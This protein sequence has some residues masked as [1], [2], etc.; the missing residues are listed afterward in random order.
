ML[1][2][3]GDLDEKRSVILDH[4]IEIFYQIYFIFK[5][6]RNKNN[7]ILQ[8]NSSDFLFD[9]VAQKIERILDK[10]TNYYSIKSC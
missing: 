9:L 1:I 8:L 6:L 4:E 5:I 10:L 2:N 7:F 3:V